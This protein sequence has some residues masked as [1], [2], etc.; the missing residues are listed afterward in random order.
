MEGAHKPQKGT[1]CSKNKQRCS[2]STANARRKLCNSVFQ[3]YYEKLCWEKKGE[4][5][6]CTVQTTVSQIF[7]QM[8]SFS[9]C[10]C[11]NHNRF[12][13][14]RGKLYLTSV[15]HTIPSIKPHSNNHLNTSGNAAFYL[16]SL[17]NLGFHETLNSTAWYDHKKTGSG[18]LE[19]NSFHFSET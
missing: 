8:C 1:T 11:S 14:L 13:F 9:G 17:A 10:A 2:S 19:R 5:R 6:I 4:R 12:F 3:M 16:A 7:P 18:T 15:S